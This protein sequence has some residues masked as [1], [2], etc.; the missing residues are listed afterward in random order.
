MHGDGEWK[1][2]NWWYRKQRPASDEA[3]FENMIHVIFQ[4]GLNWQVIEKK[5]PTTQKAFA[6]F[7]IAKVAA[8]TNKDVERLLKDEGIVRNRAKICATITNAAEFQNIKKQFGSFQKYL[9]SLDKSKNYA[10]VVNELTKRFK[11]MGPSSAA[12]FLYT[13]GEKIEPWGVP[14]ERVKAAAAM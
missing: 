14:D 7:N 4:A 8:F 1:M 5:W 6:E 12:T 11:F 3:Y 13:V 10:T 2:P 9:D